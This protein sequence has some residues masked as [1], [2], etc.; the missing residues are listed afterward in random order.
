MERL[1]VEL[2][3]VLDDL[4][5]GHF[6]AAEAV[7]LAD[8]DVL[9][10]D[11]IAHAAASRRRYMVRPTTERTSSSRWFR[12]ST[13]LLTN[14]IGFV[15]DGHVS[16]T[17]AEPLSVSPGR[18]GLSHRPASTPG[19]PTV[20]AWARCPASADSRIMIAHVCQPLAMSPPKIVARAASGSM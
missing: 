1:R 2:S 20:C 17:S 11:E 6:V 7:P 13:R 16:S 4:A 9:E 8:D 19:E 12:S 14:P 18:T 3:G 10:I 15:R 5:R